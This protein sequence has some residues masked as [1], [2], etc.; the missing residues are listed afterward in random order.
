MPFRDEF[1]VVTS[2][3][4]FGHILPRDEPRFLHKLRDALRP[5]GRFV[6]ATGPRPKPKHLWFWMAHGFN[7]VMRVRNAI[8]KPEFIMYYLT[9]LWPEV[10][11]KLERAGFRVEAREGRVGKPFERAVIVIATKE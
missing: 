3:G 4:A 11:P 7:A 8:L 2:V 5:G 10:K 6:F 9:L 1:D